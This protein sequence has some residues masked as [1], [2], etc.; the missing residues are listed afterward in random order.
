[1]WRLFVHLEK[2]IKMNRKICGVEEMVVKDDE[3]L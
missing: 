2:L 3:Y 1:M